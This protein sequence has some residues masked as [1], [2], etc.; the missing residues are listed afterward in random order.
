MMCL[1]V[2]GLE[3]SPSEF[4]TALVRS[5]GNA[6]WRCLRLRQWLSR[7][8]KHRAGD[9]RRGRP[10]SQ[11]LGDDHGETGCDLARWAGQVTS[12]QVV[13]VIYR[14]IHQLSFRWWLEAFTDG[15]S[16]VACVGLSPQE[17]RDHVDSF[18]V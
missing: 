11:G 10:R 16:A 12:T 5:R 2:F 8:R 13:V 3:D 17:S 15:F 14:V 1:G 18:V 4:P 7:E 9:L 6:E